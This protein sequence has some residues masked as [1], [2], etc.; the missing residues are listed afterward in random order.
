MCYCSYHSWTVSRLTS[1]IEKLL[2][3]IWFFFRGNIEV[4][5]KSPTNVDAVYWSVHLN[6]GKHFATQLWMEA[7][8]LSLSH[9]LPL[10]ITFA[11]LPIRYYCRNENFGWNFSRI[12]IFQTLKPL[13]CFTKFANFDCFSL[14]E[15]LCGVRFVFF[16]NDCS[17]NTPN[18]SINVK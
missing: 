12:H 1:K 13:P 18:Y 10:K 14:I 7:I 8:W 9:S 17:Q 4:C 6:S 3:E 2:K 5:S 15:I 11:N 16:C